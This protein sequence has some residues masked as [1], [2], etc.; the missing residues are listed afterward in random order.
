MGM[1]YLPPQGSQTRGKIYFNCST[2]Y[3]DVESPAPAMGWFDT[4]L[5]QPNTAG[6]WYVGGD[7]LW[8]TSRYIFEIPKAWADL[9]AP[10]LRLAT[11]RHR[12]SWG[13]SEGPNM[14][15][16]APWLDGNPPAAGSTLRNTDTLMSFGGPG[17]PETWSRE[18]AYSDTYQGG[19]WLTAGAKSAVIV[20]GIKDINLAKSYYGYE[21]WVT[22]DRCEPSGTCEG[23]RG[24]RCGDGRASLLFFDPDELAAV[25]KGTMSP[26]E[27]QWY[28]RLDI[29]SYMFD[30][31]E[32]TYLST[33][34]EAESLMVTY[35][36]ARQ[37]LYLSESY[38]IGTE[39]VIHVFAVT[40]TGTAPVD[41][42]PPAKPS[43][44]QL[45]VAP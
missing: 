7:S 44:L 12:N 17:H 37:I 8:N 38:A 20:S 2:D 21:N 33:G 5:S 43:N 22:P 32:P 45:Q 23:Q 29:N 25:V 14:C 36:R 10:G 16:C 9:N 31:I 41:D 11:G 18:F 27:P 26:N 1:T 15:L 34:A 40:G 28:A 4:N 19:A 30:P 3:Q 42:V 39:P 35:D 13:D 24:W 6:L